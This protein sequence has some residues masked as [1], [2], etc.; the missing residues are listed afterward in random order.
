LLKIGNSGSVK[1][2]IAESSG[3]RHGAYIYGGLL[4]NRLIGDY[5]EIPSNDIGLLLVGY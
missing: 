2:A 4:V 3:F 5:Y 1:S